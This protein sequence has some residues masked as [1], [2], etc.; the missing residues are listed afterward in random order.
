MQNWNAGAIMRRA[1][2]AALLVGI[3]LA[4]L[5]SCTAVDQTGDP[6][7]GPSVGILVV[8]LTPDYRHESIPAG[9]RALQDLGRRLAETDSVEE[10]TVDIIDSEGPHAQTPPTA[11]PTDAARLSKYD[12]IVFNNSNDATAP[13][14]TETLVLGPD[15]QAAFEEY[16]RSGGGVVGIHSA[17]DNQTPGSFFSHVFGTY[18]DQHASFQEGTIHVTDRV[19]P[20]TAHLPVEWEVTSEWYT[21]QSSP[22]GEAHI[23][24]TAD[25]TSYDGKRMGGEA[26]RHP[27]AWAREVAGGRAWYTALG[28]NPEIFRD[29]KFRMHLLGGIRWAAGLA[30][31]GA[32]GTVWSTYTK[33]PLTT[34]TQSPTTLE[35]AP[36][37]RVFYVDRRDYNNDST[38]AIV[39]IDPE[40]T[41]KTTVLELPVDSRRLNGLKGMVLDPAFEETGWIYLFYGPRSGAIETPHNRLSR[42]TVSN[43]TIDRSTE[44]EILRVP[45]QR[46]VAGHVGGDLAWGPEGRQLYL[47]LGDDTY[48]CATGYA[49][50]DERDGRSGYDAQRTSANT[51]DLRGSILRIIPQD[52][53]TYRVPE[54]NLFTEAKGYETEIEEGRVRPEIYAMGMRN[55]YRITVDER[56][57]T[58]YWGDYGPDA[59][60]WD[61]QRG[62]LGTV[63]YN[64][65]D[66][67]GFYGWPYFTGENV[68]YKHYNFET[69]ASGRVFSAERPING[70][71]NNTGLEELPPAQGSMIPAPR[72]LEAYLDYPAEWEE[73]VPYDSLREVPFPQLVGGAPMQG[74]VYDHKPGY[75]DSALPRYYEGKAFIMERGQNWI[76]YITFGEEGR[77]VEV[78]PFLPGVEFKRPMDLT[79]G[80]DGALYLAEWGTEYGAPNEDSGIYRIAARQDSAGPVASG[81]GRDP[82][83]VS[84]PA[85][86]ERQGASESAGG[87][88]SD[89]TGDAV[90]Q[91]FTIHPAGNRLR[92][93][94]TEFTVS[95][96]TKVKV[97]FENTA[98]SPRLKHNVVL[99]NEPPLDNV[100]R[101]VGQAAMQTED[102]VP[103]DPAVLAG[104]SLAAPGDTV[105]T[106]FTA[107]TEAGDYGYV[108]TFTG[109]W[110]TMQGT[111]HV[112]EQKPGTDE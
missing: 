2:T 24:M 17:I 37:G 18:Y 96:G 94:E 12:V 15:Q 84:D 105:S 7:T 49:P 28:H 73:H 44:T 52:D 9:N 104:T 48:C 47:S 3:S 62:P 63:E 50:L 71:V 82:A 16:V 65:A 30:D 69:K 38:D 22:R 29:E 95:A 13:N 43:G 42:F 103:E 106:T 58:L 102:F 4:F 99:L 53:G 68:P 45:M 88:S 93:E 59:G 85:R 97:I 55:P 40:T 54:G 87:S 10:V 25:E 35:V 76:K 91:T 57:G 98:T 72:S 32:A 70:S 19:H 81:T 41:A 39:A 5:A 64:R 66:S 90:A 34:D 31:G 111:M 110:A 89:A 27:M 67:P 92:Y 23:L 20:S 101:R 11:F 86:L 21:F 83:T 36:D 77:P 100:F 8:S 1:L 109:H 46:E 80:P 75:G 56:T 108:C 6:S 79:V 26:P 14:S 107:P 74:P 60:S 33:T 51:A 112:V 61:A 78:E